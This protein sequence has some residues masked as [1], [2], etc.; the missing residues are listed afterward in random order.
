MAEKGQGNWD[1]A[2][3]IP[4]TVIWLA[5][6][7]IT[8]A[9]FLI[10]RKRALHFD[11]FTLAG[12]IAA[13][14]GVSLRLWCRR[15]MGREFSYRLRIIEG[16]R[17]ARRGPYRFVRHP[18]YTGDL[19]VHI[20]LPLIFHSFPGCAVMVLLILPFLRRIEVEEAML[21]EEFSD[22]YRDY[23]RTTKR[24]IPFIY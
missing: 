17:L 10:R 19:M 16:H 11:G 20:G 24:F 2:F 5:G 12:L 7:I 21:I 18:A 15:T 8:A 13:I 6:L 3:V 22:E 9:D 1:W 14:A 4:A 23:R